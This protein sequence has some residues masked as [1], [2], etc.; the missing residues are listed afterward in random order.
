[1]NLRRSRLMHIGLVLPLM[2]GCTAGRPEWVAVGH[3][4][5]VA[6]DSAYA[7][8]I[9]LDVLKAGGNAIDAATAVS[10]ALAVTRPESTG[11]GG[12]GF[13]IFRLA[14]SGEVHVFD[15]RETAPAASA[16]DMYAQSH[17]A[18]AVNIP[19]DDLGTRAGELPEDRGARIVMVCGIGKFSKPATLYLKSL[20]YRNVRN[21]KGGLGE[22][23][24][25]GQPVESS[26]VGA[27]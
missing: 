4:G 8:Q 5:M 1:M 3:R 19:Q 18:G 11:L 9:G 13:A 22:W 24:R 27:S 2:A 21:L 10:F 7:S 25:K 20:G 14:D 6:T 15:F 17:I 26:A 12:G 16:P 23:V